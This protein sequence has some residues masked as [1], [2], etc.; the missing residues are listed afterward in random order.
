MQLTDG[1]E[2]SLY[3]NTVPENIDAPDPPN[4]SVAVEIGIL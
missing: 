2:V 1:Y 3:F 4:I